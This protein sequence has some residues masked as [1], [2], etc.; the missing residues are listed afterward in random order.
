MTCPEC[1]GSGMYSDGNGHFVGC[2]WCLG[3]GMIEEE[4]KADGHL[5]PDGD[6]ARS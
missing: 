3:A 5:R 1:D 2:D 6:A 4:E